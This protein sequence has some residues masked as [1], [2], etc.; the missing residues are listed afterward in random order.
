M[1]MSMFKSFGLAALAA[2]AVAATPAEA[3]TLRF[4]LTGDYNAVWNVVQN[5]TAPMT[6]TGATNGFGFTIGEA[7]GTFPGS[8]F[9][10]LADVD[11]YNAIFGGGLGI[12]EPNQAYSS[13]PGAELLVL[14]GAQLYTGSELTP[15]F[16]LGTFSLRDYYTG[17]GSYSLTI[18]ECQVCTAVPEPNTWAMMLVGFGAMGGALRSRKRVAGA[19]RR[20]KV[21]FN[22]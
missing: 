4:T 1:W 19:V 12:F 9:G 22:A 10:Y 16:L 8:E 15:T 6:I 7:Q 20:V 13:T 14:S 17:Q 18:A 2:A 5:P 21:A 11:F 3:V